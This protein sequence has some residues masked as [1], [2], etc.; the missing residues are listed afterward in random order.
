MSIT[1]LARWDESTGCT[2]FV[3]EGKSGPSTD[4]KVGRAT[5]LSAGSVAQA[6]AVFIRNGRYGPCHHDSTATLRVGYES[7]KRT[8]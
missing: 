1:S 7:L 8:R 3:T 5:A 6:L 4:I 2:H